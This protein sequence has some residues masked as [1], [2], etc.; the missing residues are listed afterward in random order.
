MTLLYE[1]S[2]INA[3]LAQLLRD[4]WRD[5]LG[6]V[7]TLK[8]VTGEGTAGCGQRRVYHRHGD[9]EKR[10]QRRH[11]PAAA[12]GQRQQEGVLLLHAYD[13]L[14]GVAADCGG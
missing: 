10:P 12:V 6:L 3:K 14:M 5:Q 4:T 11:G 7:V 2:D 1:E 13:M 8:G 9:A